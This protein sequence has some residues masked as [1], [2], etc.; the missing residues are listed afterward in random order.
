MSGSN[1]HPHFATE[2]VVVLSG[3]PSH[4]A[5]YYRRLV[6]PGERGRE[7]E[8]ERGRATERERERERERLRDGEKGQE[9]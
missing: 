8:M 6:S 9:R 5:W 4:D 1:C 7:T 3:L 2:A